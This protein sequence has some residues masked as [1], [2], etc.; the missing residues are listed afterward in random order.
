MAE[1]ISGIYKIQ[2]KTFP[3]KFYI[4]SS[5]SIVSR[6]YNHKNKLK[7]NIHH[8]P[9]IQSF[10]N[11][12]GINDLEFLI[13]EECN[14]ENLI[15]REQYYIDVLNPTFNCRKIAESNLGYKMS[16]ET[17]KKIGDANRGNILGPMSEEKK[18]HLREV[19]K[20][21]N[22][23]EKNGSYGIKWSKERKEKMS[24]FHKTRIRTPEE[25]RNRGNALKGKKKS[26]ENLEK[27]WNAN[28][29][30]IWT[31]E[32]KSK[33]KKH[34]NTALSIAILQYNIDNEFIQEWCSISEVGRKLKIKSG[35]I[36]KVLKGKRNSAGGYIWKYK[37]EV[38][39]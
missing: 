33:R 35:N 4:G 23:G 5:S 21:K 37:E 9:I 29:G 10:V 8:S 38:T 27:M 19:L 36:C 31:E 3:N 22:C 30:R 34:I 7:K 15:E 12:Y 26:P 11:K 28:R 18:Q 24:L 1:K 39:I 20:G 17:K 13:L 32:E 25:N 6:F 2:S 16:E 14:N